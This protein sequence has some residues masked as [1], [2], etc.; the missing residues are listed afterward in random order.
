MKKLILLICI[1][2]FGSFLSL[3]AQEMARLNGN[4]VDADNKGVEDVVVYF[5]DYDALVTTDENGA[6]EVSL[7]VPK[8]Y[9]M[10]LSSINIDAVELEFYLRKDSTIQVVVNRL[11]NVI[12]EITVTDEADAFGIRQLRAIE[13]GG[14]YEGKKTEVI[15][16][17]KMV[18]NK[19]ANN[20]RQTFAKVPSLNIWE[21]DQ[22]GLQLDIGGRGLSPKRT[23]NFNTRQNGYDMSAD[24]LGY[25]ESYY[26]PPMQAVKQIEL[27]KGAGAL[28]YGSQFGGMINFKL[29]EGDVNKPVV[30]EL[31][32]TYGS[33][34]FFNSFTSLHGQVKKLNYY[35]YFQY[36]R[37]DGWRDNSEFHQY[38]AYSSLN[39][40]ASEKFKIGVDYTFMYYLS[41]QPGGHTDASFA[42]DPKASNRERNWFKVNWNLVALKFEYEINPKWK[43]YSRTFGLVAQRT[44]LGLL[45]TPNL[46]DP[47]SN[48]DLI[49][50]RFRNFGNE[51]RFVFSYDTKKG[52]RNNLLIGTRVYRGFTNF[53]QQFGTD[54]SDAN[55]AVVDTAFLKRRKSD[56]DFPNLNV[57]I[58][59]EKIF[60]LSEK[61]S[62]IPGFRYEYILT[63][64]DGTYSNNIKLN[65]FGDF[66]EEIITD[67]TANQHRHLFLYG[68]GLSA[69]LHP[70]YEIYA[71]ATAN[72]RA[73]NFTDVQIQTNLQVVDPDI[74]DEKGYSFDVGFR[75]RSFNPFFIEA[76]LFYLYYSERIGEVRIDDIKFRTNIGTAHIFGLELFAEL[77]F[78]A[79]FNK[80]SH[81]KLTAFVNGSISRG[82]YG[83]VNESS[84]DAVS[85]SNRVEELPIYNIKSGVTYGY[86]DFTL[87]LQGT[88]VGNQYSDAANSEFSVLGVHGVLPAYNVFD[89]SAKYKFNERIALGASMNNVFNSSYFTRRAAAYP[90]PG[91]IP[92]L[93]RTWNVTL[94]VKMSKKDEKELIE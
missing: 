78:L 16:L 1:L 82:V 83:K 18:A 76:S 91:I 85:K 54:S 6:F 44:S 26:S 21:S 79:A 57:A 40:Q 41:R 45:E 43:M 30:L 46:P 7:P 22:A 10:V 50:G 13:D 31:N 5:G 28:Q 4:V 52:L 88:F 59:A 89:L 36:K 71:N 49:D 64:S 38:G 58:F 34:N 23:S 87:S 77:D 51:N 86:K 12:D 55:F 25:P 37:G 3:S 94:N 75:R 65:S 81:H 20:A 2:T 72:Y 29:K 70:K 69:K 32:N 42:I 66:R 67:T 33:D 47:L 90:G 15:N 27:V 68:L 24:A 17:E 74:Q 11:E 39:L 35:N 61:V 56:Y 63:K 62:L 84:S 19:A 80:E 48:R 53:S 60:R 14:L 73:I 9:K 93:G 92:A 8:Q